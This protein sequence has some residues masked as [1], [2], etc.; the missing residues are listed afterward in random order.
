MDYHPARPGHRY[1]SWLSLCDRFPRTLGICPHWKIKCAHK[2]S[3]LVH[4]LGTYLLRSGA[5]VPYAAL[6]GFVGSGGFPKALAAGGKTCPQYFRYCLDRS[7]LAFSVALKKLKTRHHNTPKK[8]RKQNKTKNPSSKAI[9]EIF[10][11]VSYIY[12][13]I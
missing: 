8:L 3:L 1:S 2:H 13:Y 5:A 9:L 10:F 6:P 4:A 11:Q 12:I 7:I